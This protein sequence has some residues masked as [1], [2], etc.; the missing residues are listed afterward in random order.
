MGVIDNIYSM[1][2]KQRQEQEAIFKMFKV[3]MTEDNVLLLPERFRKEIGEMYHRI[4]FSDLIDS[5]TG[6]SFTPAD[7]SKNDWK[8]SSA[9]FTGETNNE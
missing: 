7:Y 6:Y 9:F 4:K 2:D 8:Q 5:D 3:K 1:L